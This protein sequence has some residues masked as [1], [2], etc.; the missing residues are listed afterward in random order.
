MIVNVITKNKNIDLSNSL[1][2]FE[3]GGNIVSGF[4]YSNLPS[5]N[6]WEIIDFVF[7]QK[8]SKRDNT[9]WIKP[10]NPTDGWN[11][12]SNIMN[13]WIDSFQEK[14]DDSVDPSLSALS[15]V[16]IN[17]GRKTL[18]DMDNIRKRKAKFNSKRK[19]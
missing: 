14:I 3:S 17:K 4:E 8:L 1:Y 16:Q 2:A 12:I 7:A 13:S 6:E 19:W 5:G 18:S 9:H 10:N 11:Y 15:V